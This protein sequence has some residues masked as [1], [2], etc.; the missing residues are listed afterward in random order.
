MTTIPKVE[1]TLGGKPLTATMTPVPTPGSGDPASL[2]MLYTQ[3]VQNDKRLQWVVFPPASTAFGV[4]QSK[5]LHPNPLLLRR[6]QD[7]PGNRSKWF[8]HRLVT[9]SDSTTTLTSE[10]TG[11]AN[12][13][14]TLGPVVAVPLEQDDYLAVW[15]GETPHKALRAVDRALRA[16]DLS[17]K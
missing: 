16:Y 10:L 7:F 9:Y 13:G 15:N 4:D 1:I 11:V 5:I 14:W 8:H 3:A 17:V 2:F 12:D 6:V